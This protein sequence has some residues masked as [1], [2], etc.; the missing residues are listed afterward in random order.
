SSPAVEDA[1]LGGVEPAPDADALMV[2]ERVVEA[3]PAD[4]AAGADSLGGRAGPGVAGVGVE[5]VG[6]A[7]AGGVPGPAHVIDE[8][9]HRATSVLGWWMVRN[10]PMRSRARSALR[11]RSEEHT[12]ELQSRENLVC[13]LLL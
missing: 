6:E 2:V 4:R 5:E 7:P 1:P 12:S 8:S 10:M 3:V 13:R 11:S 9:G